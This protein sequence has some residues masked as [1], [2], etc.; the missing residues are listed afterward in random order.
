MGKARI[1]FHVDMNSFY[2]SVEQSHNPALKGKAIA[3]AGNPKERRGIIVTSSYEARHKGIYTTMNVGEAL[4]KCPELILLPPDF[5]KYRAASKA[6]FAI[7]R[8]YSELIE[9][10]SIDEGYLDITEIAQERH[11]IDIAREIQLRIMNELDLPCSIGIAPNKFLA[12]TASDMKKPMG[13]TILRKREIQEKLWPLPVIEM[14]GVGESTA[15]K[16]NALKIHTIGELANVDEYIIR[17]SLG[18]NGVRL[19][20]RANGEDSREVD[21]NAIFETKSVGNST[22]LPIDETDVD[23]LEKTFFK[24]SEKVAERLDAKKLCGSTISI[25]IRDADWHNHSKSKTFQ[26]PVYNK[27]MIF[28]EAIKLFHKSWNGAPIRLLGVTVSN[29]LER[30][31]SVEQLSIFNFE[32]FAK[33]EPIY[34]LIDS[35]EKKFGKGIIQKGVEIDKTSYASKTSFSKDFLEDLKDH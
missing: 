28:E 17:Q 25:Q 12:K 7:L 15:K 22:T 4:R 11:P 29:V 32:H 16:L 23:E 19:R 9:P 18:K 34:E 30:K 35:I 31:Q 13:I 3:I 33:Q 8:S 27:E 24:L 26:N 1:I 6:M 14:H 10:V 5:P 21:P 20:M 2:A